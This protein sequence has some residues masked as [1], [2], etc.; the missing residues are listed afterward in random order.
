MLEGRAF[1][2]V[3]WNRQNLPDPDVMEKNLHR[4]VFAFTDAVNAGPS[5]KSFPSTIPGNP[6]RGEAGL[7]NSQVRRQED[8]CFLQCHTSGSGAR[9]QI[10]PTLPSV[11]AATSHVWL[12]KS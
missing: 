7:T 11:T 3:S 2:T 4:N 12:L 8:V 1:V 5:A 9:L 6:R 10:D